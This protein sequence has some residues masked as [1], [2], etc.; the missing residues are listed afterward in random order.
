MQWFGGDVGDG[1]E[2]ERSPEPEQPEQSSSEESNPEV[3]EA[4]C[5]HCAMEPIVGPRFK[6]AICEDVSLCRKCYKRRQEIHRPSHRFFA[7]KP[8]QKPRGDDGTVTLRAQKAPVPATDTDVS[9]APA[10]TGPPQGPLGFV[11]LPPAVPVPIVPAVA[12]EV[13]SQMQARFL[14]MG[15][16]YATRGSTRRHLASQCHGRR[17]F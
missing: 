3:H 12:Q 15:K 17:E 9:G 11:A 13:A 1:S 6:C 8:M 4:V 5:D 16:T 2:Q 10:E 7:M 14:D